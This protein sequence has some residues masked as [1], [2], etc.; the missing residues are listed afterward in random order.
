MDTAAKTLVRGAHYNEGFL[1]FGLDRLGLCLF[2]DCVGSLSVSSRLQHCA[3]GFVEFGRG[4]DFHGFGDFFDVADGFEAAFDFAEG[5]IT[6]GI[7]GDGPV[8]LK[9]QLTLTEKCF[10]CLSRLLN[11]AVD[12]LAR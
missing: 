3:L 4:N 11:I 8:D 5:G 1:I 10:V 6:S 9:D 2:E 7:C 12:K